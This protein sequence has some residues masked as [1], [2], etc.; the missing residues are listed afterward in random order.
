MTTHSIRRS[1]YLAVPLAVAFAL[2]LMALVLSAGM[3]Q[4]GH[5]F[6]AMG[7]IETGLRDETTD[8][9]FLD[10]GE[11][12]EVQVRFDGAEEVDVAVSF[13]GEVVSTETVTLTPPLHQF[14]FNITFEAGDEGVWTVVGTTE[15]CTAQATITVSAVAPTASPAPL[16]PDTAVANSLPV[17]WPVTA[18]VVVLLGGLVLTAYGRSSQKLR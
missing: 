5:L 7:V 3:T 2:S 9:A 6:C 12:V 10:V 4:A 11:T 1:P 8:L 16:L 15:H 18:S 13:G 14:F 17:V